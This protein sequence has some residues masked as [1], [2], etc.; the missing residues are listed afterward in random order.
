MKAQKVGYVPKSELAKNLRTV[1]TSGPAVNL[2]TE[3]NAL[4][5]GHLRYGDLEE[6]AGAADAGGYCF[7]LVVSRFVGLCDRWSA[8][9]N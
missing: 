1:S 5:P 7:C 6:G 9:V 3:P 8:G 4:M 2:R